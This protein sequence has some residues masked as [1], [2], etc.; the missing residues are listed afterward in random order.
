MKTAISLPDDVFVRVDQLARRRG[1][2]RSAVFA[3]AADEYVR[4]HRGEEVTRRLDEI[5]A[6][7]DSTLDPVLEQL[8]AASLPKEAW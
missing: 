4:Q 8:Q 2:S 5:Y 3:A 7:A 1:M 6:R